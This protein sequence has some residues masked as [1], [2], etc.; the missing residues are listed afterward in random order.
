MLYPPR[1]CESPIFQASLVT[2]EIQ[3]STDQNDGPPRGFK[4]RKQINRGAVVV[5]A[6]V[7]ILIVALV[8]AV[9]WFGSGEDPAVVAE[10]RRKT[11]AELELLGLDIE[12]VRE[13][14]L[15]LAA[16]RAEL[17][18]EHLSGTGIAPQV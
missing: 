8:T 9:W 14:R 6:T 17:T 11:V 10:R 15:G 5:V 13:E 16:L 1:R 4:P 3:V 18:D 2:S 7:G 12:R